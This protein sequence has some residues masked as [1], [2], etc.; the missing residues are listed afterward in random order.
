M[1]TRRDI[2]CAG[3]AGGIASV[4]P[5][6]RGELPPVRP[7]TRAPGHHWCGYYDKLQSS[8][9][10]RYVLGMRTAFEHRTPRSDDRIEIGMVDTAEDDIWIGLGSSTAWGWQ[11]GCML[12][13]RPGSKSEV[14]W[15]DREDGR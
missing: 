10:D 5:R 11:Q 14:V 12:Q 9:D 13:W 1:P 6:S 15:N 7:L 3:I 2:L 4:W 8:P